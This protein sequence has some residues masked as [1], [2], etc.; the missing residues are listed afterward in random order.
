MLPDLITRQIKWVSDLVRPPQ[1]EETAEQFQQTSLDDQDLTSSP[2]MPQPLPN[3][4]TDASGDNWRTVSNR[5]NGRHGGRPLPVSGT[6][7]HRPRGERRSSREDHLRSRLREQSAY[8]KRLENDHHQLTGERDSLE[9]SC[10]Q[11]SET[12]QV[13]IT[14]LHETEMMCKGQQQKV[15]VLKEKLR[16]TSAL[17]DARNQEMNAAKTFLSKEDLFSTSDVVQL[18]RDLNSGI[19]QTATHLA[20][21]LPLKRLS[22]PSAEEVPE[23]PYKS[24]FVTLILSQGPEEVD[25]GSLEL[26]LQGFLAFCASGVANTWGFGNT[27]GWCDKLYSKVCETGAFIGR[28]L[29]TT[30]SN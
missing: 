29:H 1:V 10:R 3:H 25:A 13:A 16:D 30:T 21:T 5:T 12:Y 27:S 20:E 14:N 18:V 9:R 8:I 19:M 7:A 24:I 11:L 15:N 23:G 22:T 17:L 6:G 2:E 26:T 4:H 28:I